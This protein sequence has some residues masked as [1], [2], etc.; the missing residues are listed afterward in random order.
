MSNYGPISLTAVMGKMLEFIIAGSIRD[1]LERHRL[2]HESQHHFT[3]IRSSL[4]SLLFNNDKII[5]LRASDE[6]CFVY[7]DFRSALKK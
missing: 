7:R 6:Y 4:T 2:I 3:K 5:E 1:H